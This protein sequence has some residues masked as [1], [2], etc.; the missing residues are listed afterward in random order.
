MRLAQGRMHVLFDAG[1]TPTGR[2]A[3]TAHAAPLALEVSIGRNRVITNCG[4]AAHLNAEWESGCRVSAAHSTLTLADHSPAE[5]S[6]SSQTA[7]RKLTNTPQVFEREREEDDE[8]VW[9]LAAHD[10]Y[11]AQYGLLHYR[12]LFLGPDGS[13]LRGEDTLSLV[14]GGAKTLEKARAKRKIPDGPGFTVRFH[15]HP[16]VSAE[17]SDKAILLT[18]ASGERWRMLTSGGRIALEDSIYIPRPASPRQTKQIVIHGKLLDEGGQVRWALKRLDT[19][20]DAS[21]FG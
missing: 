21:E 8:G 17:Q 20:A 1:T 18:M 2:Y 14:K 10:G 3:R 7:L 5:L 13:D 12:R 16:D 6:G 4:S 11:V 9:A 19:E 15:L